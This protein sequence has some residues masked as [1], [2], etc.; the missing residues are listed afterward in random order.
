MR[1]LAFSFAVAL[2]ASPFSALAPP[3]NAAA[4]VTVRHATTASITNPFPGNIAAPEDP[5]EQPAQ[6]DGSGKP[7]FPDGAEETTKP[8]VVSEDEGLVSALYPDRDTTTDAMYPLPCEPSIGGSIPAIPAPSQDDLDNVAMADKYDATDG[9]PI[10][11]KLDSNMLP[12]VKLIRPFKGSGMCAIAGNPVSCG[13]P[14]FLDDGQ[15]FE[16]RDIIYV[17]GFAPEQIKRRIAHHTDASQLWPQDAPA[18]QSPGG[19]FRKYADAYWHDHIHE[20]LFD[21][22]TPSNPVAG[23]QWTNSDPVPIYK[24]KANRYLIIAWNSNQTL[25]Y[26][27]S[28]MLTQIEAAMRSGDNVKT[29]PAFPA[30]Q[31]RP[32]CSN[33]CII[34]SHSTGALLTST[35]ISRAASGFFGSGAKTI[36]S[37]MRLHVS[38]EGAISGSR[39]ATLAMVAAAYTTYA[40]TSVCALIDNLL[41]VANTCLLDTS[42]FPQSIFRDLMPLVAQG[43][44]GPILDKSPIP[45]VTLAGGHPIGDQASATKP[46]LPG[47]DDGVVSMNSSCGNPIMVQPP[48]LAPSGAMVTSLVKAFE[49]S[50]NP[51]LLA[52][53]VKQYISQKDFGS[54]LPPGPLFL[55]GACTPYLSPTGMVIPVLAN[56]NATPWNTRKRY[57]N[58]YS[59]IQGVVNHSYD[60]GGVSSNL[61]PSVQG[62]P[63]STTRHYKS[64]ATIDNPEETSAVTDAKIYQ[65]F[66]DGTY[67]VHPSFATMHEYVFGRYYKYKLFGKTRRIWV[68][69][70]T[71]HLLDKWQI[72]QSS[73]Y[74][75]EFVGRR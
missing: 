3:A 24:P 58:H 69:K 75:Y 70:R 14:Q 35:A 73:H 27:Q 13:S 16:G 48:L 46:V 60:P 61:F 20:N 17:H 18:F 62:L 26:A 22:D 64:F 44:W 32:F 1:F 41:D 34:I 23:W 19:Y 40:P 39:L 72:K 25:E 12:P 28:A 55:A 47:L 10:A 63:A 66:A 4:G 8:Y 29:P 21:P 59:F 2:A 30:S 38:F 65:Q 15:P 74:V 49:F 45:T 56:M 53:G 43:V 31:V 6:L 5:C 52:R 68:W 51:A 71:Y 67:L 42:F 33:G 57:K 36:A 11:D 7:I 54:A 50:E 9:K 37:R